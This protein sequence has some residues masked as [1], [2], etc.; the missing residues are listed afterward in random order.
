[1][2]EVLVDVTYTLLFKFGASSTRSIETK[3]CPMDSCL[4]NW[5]FFLFFV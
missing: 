2:K 3:F 5:K 4:D 1:V